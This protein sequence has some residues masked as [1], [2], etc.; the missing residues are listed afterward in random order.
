MKDTLL[1]ILFMAVSNTAS[2]HLGYYY[3][4]RSGYTL[5]R[6]VGVRI[7]HRRANER[8]SK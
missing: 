8:V 4:K 3:G 6:S 1:L 2:T 7:G 5:G